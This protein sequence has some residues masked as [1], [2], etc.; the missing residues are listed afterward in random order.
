MKHRTKQLCK[1][2]VSW[3]LCISMIA[4]NVAPIVS[5]AAF[6]LGNIPRH[7]D[8]V[9]P[10]ALSLGDLGI[11]HASDSDAVYLEQPETD[12][13]TDQQESTASADVATG[14]NAESVA[15]PSELREPECFYELTSDEPDG[16]L[17]Q[18]DEK[19]NIRTY[20]QA[21]GEYVTLIGGYS[22]I[23]RDEDGYLRRVDNTLMKDGVRADA[24][25]MAAKADAS[26]DEEA[27]EEDDS[28]EIA[29]INDLEIDS[30]LPEREET[31]FQVQ[32]VSRALPKNLA[33]SSN[34]YY[35][36]AGELDVSLP[37]SMS[38]RNGYKLS[39]GRHTLEIIPTEGDYS[40]SMAADNAVRYSNVFAN[41]DV[42]YTVLGDSVK[43]DVILL[44]RQ[45]RNRFSY[46]LKSDTLRFH[47]DGDAVL[48]YEGSVDHPVF[49]LT[50]PVMIDAAG[51]RNRDI[52]LHYNSAEKIVTYIADQ[53][54]LDDAERVY[55]VRIDPTGAVLV[56]YTAFQLNMVT[57]GGPYEWMLRNAADTHY[58]PNINPLAGYSEYYGYCRTLITI[59]AAWESLMGSNKP[60]D[61]GPG[62]KD[63]ELKL[64][65]MTT[66]AT[67]NTAFALYVPK[68]GWDPET[69]TWNEM[70][71]QKVDDGMDQTG[72]I[73]YSQ[74]DNEHE[75][76]F[77]VTQIYDDWLNKPGSCH[78]LMLQAEVEGGDV[79]EGAYHP[80][81]P[82]KTKVS[83]AETFY[84]Q[85]SGSE[86]SPCLR[87]TWTG[88][89][90]GVDLRTLDM[91][92]FCLDVGAGV[93]ETDA[94]GRNTKG[95]L[96]HGISQADSSIEYHV[97]RRDDGSVVDSGTVRAHDE[98][99][100]PDYE[101]VDPDCLWE[102]YQD[103]NWQS[104]P[105]MAFDPL[106]LDT[107]YYVMATGTGKEI[108]EKEDGTL[109]QGTEDVTVGPEKSDEFLL[110][111][112]QASDILPRIARHYGVSTNVLRKDNQF[113]F[114]LAEAGDVIFVRNPGTDEPYTAPL[115][116]GQMEEFIKNCLLNGIDPR[117][118][119]GGEPVNLSTGSFYM[120]QTDAS[121]DDLD[122]AFAI[123]RSYNGLT[124]YFRSE[125]GMGWNSL[126]GE[127]IMVLPDGSILFTREDGKGLVFEKDGED[128]YAA[129]EGYDY[130]LKPVDTIEIVTGSGTGEEG[131]TETGDP[132]AE[133]AV[134]EEEQET[135]L[136]RRAGRRATASDAEEAA[137]ESE[138]DAVEPSTGWELTEPD[139][140][141][142]VFNSYG[143]LV[144]KKNR[145]E[146]KTSYV[147]DDNYLLTEIIAPSG[148][149]CEVT[150][151]PDGKITEI[152]LPD[153]TAVIYEYD[154]RD[155]LIRVTNPEGGTKRFEYDEN[156]R[157]TAWYDENGT[158][159][160][161]NILD[162]EGR[163][164]EQTDALGNVMY[165]EYASDHTS[166]TDNR[167]NTTTYYL[168]DQRRN[169]RIEYPNG[170]VER[171][172]YSP[173]NRIES[174]TDAN[175][176]TTS[177]TYDEDG[178]I[179]TEIREDGSS[180][181]FTY[182]EL[183]LPLTA[184][185]P[186]GNITSFTYDDL[187]NLLSMTDGAGHTT[188]YEYDE[189]SRLISMT[190]ANGGTSTFAYEGTDA[191]VVT[192]T[193]PEGGT[194]EFTY[195]EMNRVLTQTDPEGNT[196]EHGY[197]ANGWEIITTAADGGVT[198]YV[199][200]PAGE[201]L[202]I[203]DAEGAETTFTYDKMH[204]IL[205]GED[206][207][208]NT[209]HYAYD[210]NYNR[211]T[212]TDAKG[213]VTA[214]E[215]DTRDRLVSTTDALNQ[216]LSY[217]LDGN[218]N[219]TAVTDRRGNGSATEYHRV[220]NLPT[221]VTDELGNKTEYRYDKNGN[222]TGI[223]YPD[224][225]SVS[226][227]YDGADRLIRTTAQNG[228][229]TELGYDGNGN[230]TR[231]TD[232]ET[233]VYRFTYDGNNRLVKATDPLGGVTEYAY[234]GAGNQIQ[235][236]D[237]NSHT[238]GYVYD[239]VGRLKEVQDALGGTV[240]SEYDLMG[241]TLMTT[242]QNGHAT[243][244]HYDA[245][246]QV[247]AQVDA[248][249]NVTGMEY[250]SLGNVTKVIDALKG[251][252]AME[253]DAL[254]RTVK[255]TDAL[256][257]EYLYEYDEN[258]NLL[259]IT[260]PDGDTVH[261]SYDAA[262]RMTHYRDEASVVTR[263][264]YDSMGRITKAQ[265]TAGNVM[266]YEYD[267]SGNLTK[268]TDTIGRDAIYEYDIFNR[269]TA[270]TG[271]DLATTR[272]TYDALDRLTSVTL[273]DDTVTTYEY[274]QVGN[275]V[276]TT[277]PGEAV[278]TYAYDAINRLTGKVNPLGA[279]TTFQYDPKGNL[280][281]TKDGE[282]NTN[283]YLY[284][285]IDRLTTF[286]DGRNNS[287]VY[288]YDELSRLLS[289]TTPEG[290][291]TEYRYDAL[292]RMTKEKDPNELITEHQYDVMGNLIRTI[293]PKNAEISY[294]YDKH[295]ELTSITDPAGNITRYTVDMNRRVTE[296]TEKNGAKY[297]Y[298]YDPVHRLTGIETPLGL[299]RELTYDVADNVI[300]DTDNL[301]RTNTYE[302]DIMHRMTKSTNAEGGI[303][304]YGYDIRGN[305]NQLNDALGYTWNY[306]Y[307]L[308]DQLTASVD[309]EGKA[310]EY[311]YNLVG[312]L[313][314]VTKPGS[315]RTDFQYDGNY[316][317]TA[318][319][320]PKGYIYEYTYDKDNRL[321]GTKNPLGE[322]EAIAYD[323]GSRVTS[324][325]D[326][327]GLTESYTYDP[328]GNVLSV[329]ATNGLVT[330]FAYDILDNLIGVTMPSD[331]KTSYT[332]DVMGNV[333][334]TTDTMLRTTTYTY[335]AE[336]NLTSITDP[337][338]RKEVMT[339][340]IGG[341]QTGY[342]SN[343]GNQIHYDYDRLNDLV[344]KSY[345]DARDPEQKEGVKYAYDVMGQ[346]VS[347][348]DRS[349]ESKYEYDGLGRITKVT[350][351][352]GEVT[353]Y[354][355][356]GC[357][358][359]ESITYAD[360]KKVSYEYDKNDNLTKVTDRT[361]AET[362]YIY[363]VINRITEIHRPNGVSTYNTYN[364]R[365]QITDMKNIC[366]ECEW[367]ISEYH[368]TYDDRGFITGEDVKESL[369]G[370]AW[371][372]KHDGRHEN[373]HDDLYPH[374]DKH[375]NKHAKDGIYNFQI[376]GTKRSFEYDD[377]GKLV[378]STET[379]DR[380]GTYVYTYEYDDMGNRTY[381]EK[382]RN[383][384]VQESAEYTYNLS[385]QMV[386]ARLYD[387][388][389]YENVEYTYDADGNR[390]LQEEVKPDGTRKVEFTYDYTV[391]NRLKAVS[392]KDILLAAMAYDGDGNR[393][394]QLNYNLHTDDD[395][396]GNSGNGNGSNKDNTG[397]GNSSGDGTGA[398]QTADEGGFFSSL[399]G[400]F[401]DTEE[402]T[403]TVTPAETEVT[404]SDALASDSNAG[405]ILYGN[406]Y[407]S[408]NT[409]TGGVNDN[410][411]TATGDTNNTGGSTNQ[412][413]IL[414]PID[415]EVSELEDELIGLIK[416]TGMEKDYELVEYVN[417]VNR[418]HVEVLME[419]NINGIMDTAYSY[420]SQRLTNERFNGWTGYYTYDPRGSV[421]G[422]TDSDGMIWQSY[423]YNAN[424][425][426]TFGKPQYN[427]VYSY[428]AESYNPN[429]ESQYLRAR[430]YNVPNGN[431]L[432]EDSYLGNLRDPLS[433]N[434]YNYVKGSPLNYVD[435]SGHDAAALSIAQQ[436][437]NVGANI[438][439]LDGGLPYA[440]VGGA[441]VTL[442]YLLVAGVVY[443][444]ESV[445]QANKINRTDGCQTGEN[446]DSELPENTTDAGK[447]G[448]KEWTKAKKKIKDSKGKGINIK[449]DSQ[450][451]A[452]KLLK[453][454]RP[455][456]EKKPTYSKNGKSG[457]EVHPA[458]PD[459][460]N[461]KPHIKWWDWSN[462]KSSG[463]EGHIY[464][465]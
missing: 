162:D 238:T 178:N 278:Y 184:K 174:R 68:T 329:K 378:K 40:H 304:N 356:D 54:W 237:A 105:V 396:K 273:A 319:S 50:A 48:A 91:S 137:E 159:V 345:D 421:T 385:N 69:I 122:G 77:D 426:L 166:L 443:V 72:E 95:I 60:E 362:T 226:Y 429:F 281:G 366:D 88:K 89:L 419:L 450:E 25:R 289:H 53:E 142:R 397:S 330:R 119:V 37:V 252:T 422:V 357:D 402:E 9:R 151:E 367:V 408:G 21:E 371:D 78:G 277:E 461:T 360:G 311:A 382:S 102:R 441:I 280:T 440:D 38:E 403:E 325:T 164:T 387:G 459:V 346:R 310:T 333:I 318:I 415:G 5:E 417:D 214:H 84:N 352:S 202:S 424:G 288:E 74:T 381:Y 116:P 229:V 92:E 321:T 336:N 235:V 185:D 15:T 12:P 86:K 3:L 106:D 223:A 344:E 257:G 282:G 135:P 458:E 19:R 155:N 272:Y 446:S 379:E 413:G 261:M 70:K 81:D 225:T 35:N 313:A 103:S 156:H 126:V 395:W 327:M 292:S 125:F 431:F 134:M 233:R 411:G 374:G 175:G 192:F 368:Y 97:H 270:V 167:G 451:M 383:G 61:G 348:M 191:P 171:I 189:L 57:K 389:H 179:L 462:G 18:F 44:E 412:S 370:Y 436:G 271:T 256:D 293:T 428:N 149:T 444:G 452:E 118:A 405:I 430:Y 115:N 246:G 284:D 249:Q 355:Y 101:K 263:Y 64:N 242:D 279:S 241:R 384:K 109:D 183:N 455:N 234:D 377:D 193:D 388:K 312:E 63:V 274:D 353:E 204:N 359:L 45:E 372:D 127:R 200:S 217:T 177:Y 36:G 194:S 302:Y 347:M 98:A 306:Q 49:A 363:D 394:F 128:S 222:L 46:K 34:A 132:A 259:K 198:T 351:G 295:D 4:P 93:V 342:T 168:D 303:T 349:G 341:R 176:A 439:N 276:K 26:D 11:L 208:G 298:T 423:R 153:G 221:A 314:S 161:E 398:S 376:I 425:D 173:E 291:K 123:T 24:E 331:L 400:L 266:T 294:T 339:Y 79:G 245:I 433:L 315:R 343:G 210:E 232:D 258:G 71:R 401:G 206:A 141:V 375:I 253:V 163:V 205:S 219:I 207:L 2:I 463:A 13:D 158:Q 285:E 267:E 80:D 42:Q 290:N 110:Y 236:T 147:Y 337:A 404:G 124:P 338:G 27:E 380:Q 83:W 6:S 75:M 268:Q 354:R 460:G 90:Q 392:N 435:P 240:T 94:G 67:D 300:R 317:V 390:I 324:V 227:A 265:D 212:E 247:L 432:T 410:N 328:H 8:F 31:M 197:N 136:L 65:A 296:L 438:A 107:I 39:K 334:S 148:K 218:G 316:N 22:G 213:S 30:A 301:D 369:Y 416:T 350:T 180:S 59:D 216:I 188:H 20:E 186:E 120:S 10:E 7:V 283:T 82:D 361:G 464:F 437:F 96:A 457:Y 297:L 365:D 201:V 129:P 140:T 131:D 203:T 309:P 51:N 406:V 117:C 251:E 17:V 255:M 332:Y 146:H 434:R 56:D 41:V 373:W 250:D 407:G 114:Q 28:A 144:T 409:T 340:D 418:E 113:G 286:T 1:Q 187:G 254:S 182:N 154:D 386:K 269:L 199:F 111:L 190:D 335:D 287:T 55:P 465:D 260:M 228:L 391:E 442:G 130:E 239:A 445:S 262:N 393:I 305:R 47:R 299:K 449:T 29:L 73:Q 62:I 427:N 99:D 230:V 170:D 33:S 121:F 14:S 143:L 108:I 209:L 358:Q 244:W 139:G 104:E 215:Y 420:G 196:T 453:E 322:T 43:E 448:S 87:V 181:S 307:D 364:A 76:V 138:I 320:D 16:V 112:V 58:G 308:I 32:K 66:N 326:R 195:D 264:E 85:N 224:G 323:P 145:K 150:M 100:C 414:F 160:I 23:Y 456:L 243:S 454:A 169:V 157:M 211:V 172:H 165:F 275:L 447:K 152:G 231:I 52:R 248:A 399:F 220:L 133:E